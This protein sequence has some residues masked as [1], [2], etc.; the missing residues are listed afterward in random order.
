MSWRLS[1]A[2]FRSDYF[3][4]HCSSSRETHLLWSFICRTLRNTILGFLL[5]MCNH[6]C[7]WRWSAVRCWV[8]WKE[9][10]FLDSGRVLM[11]DIASY[12]LDLP[13]SRSQMTNLI[14]FSTWKTSRNI[15]FVSG[16]MILSSNYCWKLSAAAFWARKTKTLGLRWWL[17][18]LTTWL[19]AGHAWRVCYISLIGRICGNSLSYHYWR[20]VITV[21]AGTALV[22][23][24]EIV[25][26]ICCGI[27]L[28]EICWLLL[29]VRTT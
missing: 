18:G 7:Y 13:F 23:H 29:S 25:Q 26:K 24:Q 15:S 11:A 20:T 19:L 22:F 16:L 6:N 2:I 17:L 5:M 9:M 21:S 4:L 3:D 12:H 1:M 10:L 28:H 27:L 8:Y 14:L